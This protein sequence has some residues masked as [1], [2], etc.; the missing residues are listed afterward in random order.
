MLVYRRVDQ[1]WHV[2]GVCFLVFFLVCLLKKQFFLRSTPLQIGLAARLQGSSSRG[3]VRSK[4]H[5]K[6]DRSYWF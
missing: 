1:F 5:K 2:G 4:P 6:D 3:A